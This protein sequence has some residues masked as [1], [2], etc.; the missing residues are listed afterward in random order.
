MTEANRTSDLSAFDDFRQRVQNMP[1]QQAFLTVPAD[2]A[3]RMLTEHEED[4]DRMER[5][6]TTLEMLSGVRS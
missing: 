4:C 5:A 3:K 2:L 6:A 1:Q